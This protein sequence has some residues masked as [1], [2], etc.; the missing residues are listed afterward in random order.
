M[1]GAVFQN[2]VTASRRAR[3]NREPEDREKVRAD[4]LLSTPK[5]HGLFIP[6]PEPLMHILRPRTWLLNCGMQIDAL[7]RCEECPDIANLVHSGVF[8]N[9]DGNQRAVEHASASLGVAVFGGY[10]YGAGIDGVYS[11]SHL[12]AG[13]SLHW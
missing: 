12:T 3:D 8:V 6:K 9:C 4:P 2:G 1:D 5:A 7:R 11:V 13:L 10:N